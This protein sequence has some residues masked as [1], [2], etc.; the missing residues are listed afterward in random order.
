[1]NKSI[2]KNSNS[3]N[4]DND[5]MK[6]IFRHNINFIEFKHWYLKNK[7]KI[8]NSKYLT[9]SEKIFKKCFKYPNDNIAK[10]IL[11][12]KTQLKIKLTYRILK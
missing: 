10:L 12:Y 2:K 9:P 3:I 11:F 8:E 6:L 5:S 4:L 1:M 7:E